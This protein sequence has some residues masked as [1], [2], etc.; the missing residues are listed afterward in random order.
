MVTKN[1]DLLYQEMKVL[2]LRQLFAIEI[3]IDFFYR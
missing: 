3:V 2:D 1:C